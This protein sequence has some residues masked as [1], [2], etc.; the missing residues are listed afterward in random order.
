LLLAIESG[1]MPPRAS[2][3]LV[4]L[5]GRLLLE[6]TKRAHP[7]LVTRG[8]FDR[9]KRTHSNLLLG[10]D[11]AE[12]TDCAASASVHDTGGRAITSSSSAATL[13][14]WFAGAS[15]A[16]P[17]GALAAALTV[18]LARRCPGLALALSARGTPGSGR[19]SAAGSL[20]AA[21]V[22]PL[23][24]IGSII[25]ATGDVAES[26]LDVAGAHDGVRGFVELSIELSLSPV[27]DLHKRLDRIGARRVD[28]EV[29]REAGLAELTR[30]G[31]P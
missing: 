5:R 15:L 20:A 25:R 7:R 8:R 19:V 22:Q 2:L 24:G 26:L 29:S 9:A 1:K 17:S 30:R 27:F 23:L 28:E 16:L 12:G 10:H 11:G 13:G 3:S 31:Q 18:T 21:G 14:G 6:G 4:V